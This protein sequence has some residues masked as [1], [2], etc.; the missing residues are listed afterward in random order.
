MNFNGAKETSR[1]GPVISK[2]CSRGVAL[3]TLF[4]FQHIF[5]PS[6]KNLYACSCRVRRTR[7]KTVPQTGVAPVGYSKPF[8]FSSILSKF[9]AFT[10][11]TIQMEQKKKKSVLFCYSHTVRCLIEISKRARVG[12]FGRTIFVG[13]RIIREQ[14]PVDATPEVSKI[15]SAFFRACVSAQKMACGYEHAN[16]IGRNPILYR[17]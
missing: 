14:F 2:R 5:S 6:K 9:N 7:K 16:G 10:C 15:F 12:S 3:R 17:C 13:V 11:N 4:I 8:F 1:N